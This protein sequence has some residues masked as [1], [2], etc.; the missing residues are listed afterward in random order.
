MEGEGCMR[1]VDERNGTG[2]QRVR[3]SEQGSVEPVGMPVHE[4]K[5]A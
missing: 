3:V 4:Q 2:V 5:G 1:A